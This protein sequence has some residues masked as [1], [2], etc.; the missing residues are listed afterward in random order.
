MIECGSGHNKIYSLNVS[1]NYC[2]R[3]CRKVDVIQHKHEIESKFLL[4]DTSYNNLLSIVIMVSECSQIVQKE[5]RIITSAYA[6]SI[7]A[8]EIVNDCIA[9]HII[10]YVARKLYYL[11]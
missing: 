4:R 6:A 2:K 11:S 5:M 7:A 3:R 10:M 9:L 1:T 8:E